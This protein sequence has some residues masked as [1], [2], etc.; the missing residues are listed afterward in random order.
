M[1]SPSRNQRC[2]CGSG[3][4]FKHCCGDP[5]VMRK[6]GTRH[7]GP[8]ALPGG[9]LVSVSGAIHAAL[10]LQ[11]NG[12]LPEA[13]AVC[14][15]VLRNDP[16]NADALHLKGLTARLLGDHDTAVALIQRAIEVNPTIAIFHNNLAEVFLSLNRFN[17]AIEKCRTAIQLQ[18]DLPEAHFNLGRALR[19]QGRLDEAMS[20][21]ERVISQ[22]PDFAD[23]HGALGWTLTNA[24]KGGRVSRAPGAGGRAQ[25]SLGRGAHQH[26]WQ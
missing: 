23:A 4:K 15:L 9:R 14:D 1:S 22:R 3:R 25:S 2:P 16:A 5:A 24:G 6:P 10:Q 13:A 7:N 26:P 20:C 21:F 17:K 8:I 18:P 11:Q 19:G 12:R